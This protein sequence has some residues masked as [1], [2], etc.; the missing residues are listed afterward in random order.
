MVLLLYS[1]LSLGWNLKP[2]GAV[3]CGTRSRVALVWAYPHGTLSE[4]ESDIFILAR[5]ELNIEFD[6][7]C[8][9]FAE[10]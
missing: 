3:K 5:D 4:G 10:I 8:N 2:E 6:S 7:P 9:I 1:I